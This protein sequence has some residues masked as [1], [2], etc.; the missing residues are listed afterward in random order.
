MLVCISMNAW[1]AR[2]YLSPFMEIAACFVHT[3][4]SSVHQNNV[5]MFVVEHSLRGELHEVKF[6]FAS[7][8]IRIAPRTTTRNTMPPTIRSGKL[9]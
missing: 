2:R 7:A 1:V 9:V 3:D 6:Y 8:S 5:R 4:Q